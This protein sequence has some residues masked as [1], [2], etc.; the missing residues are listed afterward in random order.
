MICSNCGNTIDDSARFCPHCGAAAPLQDPEP[1]KEEAP[2]HAAAFCPNCGAALPPGAPVCPNCS[3][4]L[5]SGAAAPYPNAPY[6][7]PFPTKP[8]SRLVAA[9]LALF[10]GVFAL[11]DF[12]LEENTM[13][14]L[15]LIV[16]LVTCGVGGLI[17]GYV[18]AIRLLK[19]EVLTD[20]RGMELKDFDF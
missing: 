7:P 16:S 18:N 13:G 19:R 6:H 1:P 11:E 8:R 2:S 3:M 12:Y 14:I 9:F 10:F 15:H 17:W 20:G 5:G 4:P